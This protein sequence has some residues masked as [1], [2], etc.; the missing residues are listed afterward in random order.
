M[1]REEVRAPPVQRDE[2]RAAE[3]EGGGRRGARAVVVE[4]AATDP[5]RV[6][7]PKRER[8]PEKTPYFLS[9]S[10]IPQLFSAIRAK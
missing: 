3:P 1:H 4:R 9:F 6:E 5:R 7:V 2:G 8:P 10:M